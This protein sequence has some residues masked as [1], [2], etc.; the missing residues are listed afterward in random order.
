MWAASGSSTAAIDAF[1]SS[2]DFNLVASDVQFRFTEL[3]PASGNNTS[4]HILIDG[5]VPVEPDSAILT[6]NYRGIDISDG[7]EFDSGQVYLTLPAPPSGDGASSPIVGIVSRAT[8]GTGGSGWSAFTTMPVAGSTVGESSGTFT[9]DNSAGTIGF[10]LSQGGTAITGSTTFTIVDDYTIDLAAFSLSDGTSSY[11]FGATQLVYGAGEYYGVIVS[12]DAS[13]NYDSLMFALRLSSSDYDSDGI[14]NLVDPTPGEQA[15]TWAGF[16]IEGSAGGYYVQTGAD[17][18]Y[19]F[20]YPD[21]YTG[22]LWS[23]R[24]ACWIYL[25]E[26]WV[27]TGGT[28]AYANKVTTNPNP[29][30]PGAPTWA[31]FEVVG[32]GEAAYVVTGAVSTGLVGTLGSVNPETDDWM[33]S[34]RLKH[35]IFLPESYVQPKGFFF[36]LKR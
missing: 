18:L 14:P 22:W 13:P 27:Q 33:W 32:T 20:G 9:F 21:N 25:P 11:N 12:E 2:S 5:L 23:Y 17:F 28:W 16:P 4:T 31:G 3:S 7:S 34:Y 19:T 15:T 1:L 36:Y 8:T 35:W 29:P 26:S 24:L 6:S 10:S 30:A